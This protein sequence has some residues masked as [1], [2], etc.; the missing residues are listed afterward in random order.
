MLNI[1]IFGAPGSGKGTYSA[2]LVEKYGFAHIST[3]D[4][5]RGEISKGTELGK[6]AKS[7]TEKGQLIP[8]ELMTDILASTYDAMDKKAGVIF[9]GFPRTIAQAESLK[10]MLTERGASMG[11]MI[12]LVVEEDE[13][14]ARLLK[15]AVE[16]GRSDDNEE[17]IKNRFNVYK[18]Q[19]SPL[20]EWFE[21]E[22]IRNSFTYKGTMEQMLSEIYAAVEKKLN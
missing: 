22:G 2:K 13:L 8:D 4:V 18:T 20:I 6:I 12:E 7:Y 16:Q 9:D 3:G 21:K 5:L 1:I 19:T 14:M 11:M 15:R 10:K 17:T